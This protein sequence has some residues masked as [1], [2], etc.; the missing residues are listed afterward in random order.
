VRIAWLEDPVDAIGYAGGAE[1]DGASLREAAPDEAHITIMRPGQVRAGDFDAYVIGNCTHYEAHDIEPLGR[2]DAPLIK[3]MNDAWTEGY[4]V[5]RKWLLERT[6]LVIFRSPMHRERFQFKYRG[7]SALV[8]SAV[9][10]ELF[11]R[12]RDRFGQER[13]SHRAVWLANVLSPMR[14]GGI[15]RARRWADERG[16][17]LEEYGLGTKRGPLPYD[18]VPELL[19][20][21]G[22]LVHANRDG[23]EPFSRV[24][25]EAWAA[26][27]SLAVDEENTGALYWLEERPDDLE[28]AGELFWQELARCIQGIP[29]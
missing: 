5:V 25:V 4:P 12:A 23:F 2:V 27:C 18:R 13:S 3:L 7:E 29:V 17:D 8:P 14:A 9:D 26:G 22:W 24:V 15:S 21:S 10:L 16:V 19:A 6:A 11:R 20:R 1:L 28:R